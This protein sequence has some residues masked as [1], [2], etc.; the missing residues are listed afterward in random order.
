MP[1]GGKPDK[2]EDKRAKVEERKIFKGKNKPEGSTIG[3]EV[4]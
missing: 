4:A 1:F 2:R 3:K